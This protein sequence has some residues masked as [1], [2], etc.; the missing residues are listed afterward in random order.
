MGSCLYVYFNSFYLLH[1]Y[2]Q[3][4][5]TTKENNITIVLQFTNILN[6]AADTKRLRDHGKGQ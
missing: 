2:N 6:L 3:S 4:S 1:S 5:S